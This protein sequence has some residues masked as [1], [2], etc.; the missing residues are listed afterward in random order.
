[1][2]TQ[3]LNLEFRISNLEFGNSKFKIQNS[4]YELNI[5][6]EGCRHG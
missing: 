5:E 3:V 6:A 4:N 1:M 2:I